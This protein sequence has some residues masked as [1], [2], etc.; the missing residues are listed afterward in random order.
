MCLRGLEEL[1][2]PGPAENI[3]AGGIE[4]SAVLAA[5]DSDEAARHQID[6]WSAKLGWGV[7][8]IQPHGLGLCYQAIV[9]LWW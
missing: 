7:Q 5:L 1:R 9:V 4:A 3:V 2:L 8:A 6:V